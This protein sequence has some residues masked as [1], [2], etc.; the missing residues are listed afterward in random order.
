MPATTRTSSPHVAKAAGYVRD[1][2][3]ERQAA[4]RWVKLACERHMRDLDNSKADGSPFYFDIAAAE[5]VCQIIELFPHIKGV[6]AK[7]HKRLELEPWQLF[8]ITSVFGWKCR[9]DDCR[10]FRIAYIEVPRK[11][12]KSTVTSAVG[13]YLTACD[14]EHGAHVVSAA[15]TLAQAK[16]VFTDAQ[17]MAR[18][19]P[20]FRSRFG[21]EV[22]ARSIA[23]V[24]T[25]SHFDAISAEYSNLD[26]LNIHGAL[27]DELHAHP[28][29]GVWDILE[30]AIGSRAQPLMWAITTAGLNRASVCYDQ[31]SHALDVLQ[32]TLADDSYF[33]IVYT[34]DD[35]DDPFSEETWAKANPNYGVSIYPQGLLSE[36]SRAQTIPSQQNAFFTK[37]L[38]I[39]V[40]A[41]TS[42]LGAGQWDKCADPAMVLDDFA[43]QRCYLGIDLAWR[44]DIAALALLF[45][46]QRGR[47]EWTVF[48]RYFLPEETIQRSENTHYQG[49][50]SVGLLTSTPG[51]AT[52]YDFILETVDD[53]CSRFEAAEIVLDPHHSGPLEAYIEK[54]SLPRP[55]Q[56]KQY[57]ANMSP[58]MVELEGLVI[59]R[60]IRHDGD[61]ILSWMMSN[62]KARRNEYG[63]VRPEKES[64]DK[65][66]DGVTALL[67]C[68]RRALLYQT[69]PATRAYQDRGLWSI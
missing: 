41:A 49:W 50:E 25:A 14:S 34:V 47:E 22:T 59:S 58:A 53:L 30:T 1:V 18:R 37:H 2:L 32:G 65:K 42:W 44:S 8:L 7:A 56:M 64:E 10:R 17:N 13:L 43:G 31:R 52:D 29:R 61:P 20:G 28:S 26:G 23:Q 54:R 11:N 62:V 55:V 38:N 21:V 68:L 39:W 19:E 15:N 51:A 60:K 3:M 5:R 36:S 57:A 67:M 12:A 6:W 66:I 16:L 9:A 24:S 48:G 40:N 69:A 35:G 33:G 45:P 46:P 63:L 27:I 4:C